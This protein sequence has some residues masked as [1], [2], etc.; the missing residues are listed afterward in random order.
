MAIEIMVGERFYP[1]FNVTSRYLVMMGGRGSSK[2]ETAA[3]ILFY[4]A[5]RRRHRYLVMRK[6]RRTLNDSVVEVFKRFFTQQGIPFEH[7]IAEQV[8]TFKSPAGWSEILFRGID[9]PSKIKSIKGITSAW[10]EETTEFSKDEFETIDLSVREAE[11]D[12][13]QLILTFNPVETDAPWL[14]ERFFGATPDPDAFVHRSTILDNP[15]REVV[16]RYLP[17]LEKL[18]YQSPE[19][20]QIARLGEWARP[21]GVIFDWPVE[22]LPADIK[23]DSIFYGVDFG[24]SIDPAAVVRVYRKA[25]YYWVEELI[26][27]PDLTNQDLAKKLKDFGVG[28]RDRLYCDAAEPKSIAELNRLGRRALPAPKGQDSVR[29]G[30]NFMRSLKIRIV[31]GSQNLYNEM[32]SYSWRRDR[33]GQF[34]SEPVEYKNHLIDGT[35]YAITGEADTLSAGVSRVMIIG[36]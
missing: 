27:E 25:D 35:R 30:I 9:E 36:G 13:L 29:A 1:L 2:T 32:R 7:H 11:A 19:M 28:P 20:Y 3:R 18:K 6:V 17:I 34:T 14:K 24:F 12:Y 22:P 4:R 33:S 16:R 31:Q 21:E 10:L 8:M 26:Y 15:N 5:L 23:F